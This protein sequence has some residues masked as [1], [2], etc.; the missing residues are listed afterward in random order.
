ME[1]GEKKVAK[2]E[3]ICFSTVNF[4]NFCSSKSKIRI[5]IRIRIDPN[6]GTGSALKPMRIHNTARRPQ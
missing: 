4:F 1:A 5:R 2:K 6:P 3:G